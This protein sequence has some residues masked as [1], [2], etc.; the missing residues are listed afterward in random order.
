[1]DAARRTAILRKVKP[2]RFTLAL[3]AAASLLI[4]GMVAGARADV[5]LRRDIRA[6]ARELIYLPPPGTARL[7]SLGFNQ[8]VA[9]WYWVRA[10]QYFGDPVQALNRYRNLGD[11]LDVVVGVD[12]DYQYAYKFGGMS[13][14]YDVGRLNWANTDK[15]IDLLQRGVARFP[16]NWELHFHLGF[17]LL[18]FRKDPNSAAE[19]FAIAGQIPGSPPYLKLFATRLFSAG[20]EIDRALVFA[21]T[22]LAQAEDP[23]ERKHLED[24]VQSIRREKSL[25]EL[26]E[27]VRRYR[28]ARGQWPTSLAEVS[29][30]YGLPPPPSGVTISNGVLQIPPD[31][32]R[33]AVYQHAVDGEYQLAQ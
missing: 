19:Q 12:P 23:K 25:R 4:G 13:I 30:A 22:M 5:L 11:I 1:M 2:V 33:L 31:W 7:L 17:Y 27:A 6:G 10:L 28:D 16:Q 9:D 18:N 24:R 29:A 32:D 14:P 21:Q 15:A 8:V 3:L 26:E 20:G